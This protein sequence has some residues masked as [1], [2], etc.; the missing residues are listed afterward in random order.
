MGAVMSRST[1]RSGH[2][3]TIFLAKSGI[4]DFCEVLE[5]PGTLQE[6]SLNDSV[7]FDGTVFTKP[8]RKN[9]PSWFQFLQS[10]VEEDLGRLVNMSTS[11]VLVLRASRRVFVVTFGYGRTMLDNNIL[12][13]SFGLRVVLNIVDNHGLRSLD[14]KTVQKMTVHTRR[15]ASRASRISE[16]GFDKEEDLL[17]SVT[18][19][20]N[21]ARIAGVV[22]GSDALHIGAKL[23]FREIGSVCS[24]LLRHSKG[25]AYKKQGFEFIDHVRA[26]TDPAIRSDLDANLLSTILSGE[27]A[28]IHMAPPE[29]VDWS[30]IGGFGF[31]KGAE[32]SMELGIERFLS[33]IRRPESLNIDRLK[34]SR[35]FVHQASGEGPVRGWHVYRAIVAEQTHADRL[36]VLSCGEWYEID[37]T[38]AETVSNRMNRIGNANLGLP[39]AHDGEIESDYNERA[40]MCPGVYCLDKECPRADGDP[41]E[42]CDLYV[43]KRT[44]VHIKHWKSS[45]KLSHLFAQGRMSAEAFVSDDVFRKEVRKNLSRKAPSVG[46]QVPTGQPDP[47][48]FK[49]AFGI[50]KGGPRGWRKSLPFF[51]KLNLVRT[52]EGLR[53]IGFDVRLERIGVE[54]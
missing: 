19:R 11:A 25:D 34:G 4:S 38:F 51:S 29:I 45:S 20:T 22:S 41:I 10:G 21:D 43:S 28:G 35:V 9:V 26:V 40:G 32:P 31:T 42:A 50:I 2:S 24:S 46:N 5:E 1:G 33:Q 27:L 23:E 48:R 12:E 7:P 53:R 16:F 39:S 6:F 18:G 14:S 8:Q 54:Q 17:R 37:G 47:S 44:F 3:L 52:S 49:V 36:Y 13:R 30:R 15:Q